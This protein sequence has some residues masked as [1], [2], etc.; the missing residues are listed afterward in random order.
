MWKQEMQDTFEE[1][2][3]FG[4]PTVQNTKRNA[5]RYFADRGRPQMLVQSNWYLQDKNSIVVK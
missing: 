4:K 1:L 2:Q 5:M 3:L